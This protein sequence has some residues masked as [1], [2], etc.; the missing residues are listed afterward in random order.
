MRR[1]GGA[2]DGARFRGVGTQVD[3]PAAAGGARHAGQGRDASLLGRD[4]HG[5]GHRG[6]VRIRAGRVDDQQ[7]VSGVL[8]DRSPDPFGEL[9]GR[10]P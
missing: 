2:L 7:Q 5:P 9:G 3:V 8:A 4:A 6:I 1:Q 10:L